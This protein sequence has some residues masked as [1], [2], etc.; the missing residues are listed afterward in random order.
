MGCL[1]HELHQTSQA[2][3]SKLVDGQTKR[4]RV[5]VLPVRTK[6][7]R[8]VQGYDDYAKKQFRSGFSGSKAVYLFY[9]VASPIQ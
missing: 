5:V 1:R 2:G 7:E 6:N 4:H 3:A 9:F 8:Q